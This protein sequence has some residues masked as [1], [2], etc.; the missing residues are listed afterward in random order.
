MV[1][2]FD[3]DIRFNLITGDLETAK[4]E[5][6][7]IEK[8]AGDLQKQK[9]ML[10]LETDSAK[11]DETN[12]KI[13]EL[14]KFLSDVK[15][16]NVD[17]KVSDE[18]IQK[19]E[20]EL[21]DLQGKKLDL[22]VSVANTELKIARKEVD[23][24]NGEKVNVDVD[25]DDTSLKNARKEL[26]DLQK[27]VSSNMSG[28]GSAITGMISGLAGKS[29]WDTVYGTSAKAETNKVLIK[30]MGDTSESYTKLYNTIDKTTDSSL[31]SM[32]Q[33]I[34]AM[35]GIK[36]ATGGTAKEMDTITPKVANFG[37]YV[38]AMTGSS[39][40]AEQAMFDLSK[41]I[42]G[43]YASL[44]QYGI[45]ED[46]LMRTGLW[47]GKE[48]DVEGY[49]EAVNKVTGSTDDL[50][51]TATGMEALMGKSFSR[52]GK[53]LGESVLPAVKTLLQGFNDLDA[54]TKGWLSTTMLVG[55]GVAS[56]IVSGLSAINQAQ[57]GYDALKG[58]LETVRGVYDSVKGT[59]DTVRNA[60]S[61][62]VGVAEALG[63][64]K[65]GEAVG[66]E[67]SMFAK[68]QAIAPT[69]TL[70][71]AEYSLL[72]PILLLVG[73]ILILV[74]VLWY[75]YNNNEQVREAVDGLVASLGVFVGQVMGAVKG[76]IDGFITWL[77][78]LYNWLSQL[79]TQV[80]GAVSFVITYLSGIINSIV[81]ILTQIWLT[82][83]NWFN[84]LLNMTP[85]QVLMLII[86]VIT[87][88]NPFASLI[89][90]V[91][92][93][94][95]PVFISQATSWITNTVSRARS[96]VNQVYSA[97]SSLPS[98]VTS[99]VSGVLGA[100]TRP[101]TQAWNTIRPIIDQ[102]NSGIDTVRSV[103]H[104]GF[105]GFEGFDEDISFEGFNESLNATL[106]DFGANNQSTVQ[107]TFNINGII[108]ES[109]S[110]YIVNSVNSHLKKQNLIRGR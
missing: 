43:A 75:L 51:N 13:K 29:I 54:Q 18:E 25:V 10:K 15:N 36:S 3:V 11:L 31:I 92:S 103:L 34:P 86:G 23:D 9:L 84:M 106:S 46:A 79:G 105:E 109:A 44:D 37:Q 69:V 55:G 98:R 87:T 21:Q 78:D 89:A 41:G 30:G 97:I 96:L 88:L 33:L 35:N 60:E 16:P 93:R 19:A 2:N 38:Y 77:G 52:A 82:V 14:Q 74:G 39:A 107:N 63:M 81:V 42:K 57:Q 73:A 64:A 100:L 68:L 76:A 59:I 91:L 12:S 5:L 7:D 20:K 40:K 6:S 90:G 8:K 83:V 45:T 95:L 53:R 32:Q 108:E 101:F 1:K 22:E 65:I 50:M 71:G 67:A 102:I 27:Q 110:E 66:E 104:M 94:V 24:L 99:A 28:T 47:N 61:L 56:S 80:T 70:A 85:Q 48:D 72:I 49:M 4:K 26:D 17:V 62:S 58:S